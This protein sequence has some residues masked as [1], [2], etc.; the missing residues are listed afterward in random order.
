MKIE[1]A[2]EERPKSMECAK[3]LAI[4]CRANSFMVIMLA[5]HLQMA[6]NQK[7]T[8]A[9]KITWHRNACF[10]FVYSAQSRQKRPKLFELIQRKKINDSTSDPLLDGKHF[11]I[12]FGP[13]DFPLRLAVWT[14]V[15]F[16]FHPIK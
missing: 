6:K 1:Q 2:K 14:F 4:C 9:P 7:P 5:T 12:S 16:D 11:P 3:L 8:L 10:C 15:A 13:P